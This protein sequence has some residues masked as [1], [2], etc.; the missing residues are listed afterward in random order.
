MTMAELLNRLLR[1]R[2][3]LQAA[4]DELEEAKLDLLKSES[5]AEFA[6]NLVRYNEQRIHRL[7]RRISDFKGDIG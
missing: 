1:G 5:A 4:V 6:T 7:K 2:T 3:S